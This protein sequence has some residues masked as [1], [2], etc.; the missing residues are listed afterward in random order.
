VS[1]RVR[2]TATLAFSVVV[3]LGHTTPAS[4]A[5]QPAATIGVSPAIQSLIAQPTQATL[6]YTIT[7][8]NNGAEAAQVT[9]SASNFSTLGT[10][11]NIRFLA[12]STTTKHGLATSLLLTPIVSL[13]PHESKKVTITINGIQQLAAGG[14]YTA[15]LVQS[16]P[17]T[18][19]SPTVQVKQSVA[20]LVFLTTNGKGTYGLQVQPLRLS[21][22]WT[23][24]PALLNL[25]LKNTGNVQTTPRGYVTV[26]GPGNHLLSKTVLNPNSSLVLPGTT[27]LLQTV[28]PA[29][30]PWRPGHYTVRVYYR[31]DNASNYTLLA[32]NF[33]YI[34]WLF[35]GII[36]LLFVMAFLLL[37]VHKNLFKKF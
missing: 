32:V 18:P 29:S 23:T 24:T 5:S 30:H 31:Y 16:V 15:V 13:N 7:I 11:N 35:G 33:Y 19:G 17:Q 22:A 25:L 2:L 26:V 34:G 21:L 14:H 4:A 9:L 8:T 12:A 1:R 20:S 3:W 6:P 37:I 27:R 10:G 28:V 36:I